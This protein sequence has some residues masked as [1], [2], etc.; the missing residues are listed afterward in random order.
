MIA[1]CHVM[2]IEAHQRHLRGQYTERIGTHT[3]TFN[4]M[5]PLPETREERMA[6]EQASARH[7]T[8]GGIAKRQDAEIRRQL[9]PTGRERTR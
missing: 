4:R 9:G 7:R 1:E 8:I 2:S 3:V 5:E 6:R